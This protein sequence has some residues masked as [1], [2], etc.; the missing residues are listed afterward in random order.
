MFDIAGLENDYE[1]P[2]I[3]CSDEFEQYFRRDDLMV[4]TSTF[5]MAMFYFLDSYLK[6]LIFKCNYV[7]SDKNH[8]ALV[9]LLS[10]YCS[11]SKSDLIEL[12]NEER[13]SEKQTKGYLRLSKDL[14]IGIQTSTSLKYSKAL[15][16]LI[17]QETA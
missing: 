2:R 6:W 3:K 8:K 16:Q 5:L 13:F 10:S 11:I 12:I 17:K 7:Q 1:L 9:G 15:K 4:V 14:L